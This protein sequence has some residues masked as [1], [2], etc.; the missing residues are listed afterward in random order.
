[1]PKQVTFESIGSR[2]EAVK[3]NSENGGNKAKVN[4][5]KLDKK[6]HFRPIGQVIEFYKFFV[7]LPGGKSR[8]FVVEEE[9]KQKAQDMIL[10]IT[11]EEVKPNLRFAINVIDR[12]DSQVKVLE[13]GLMIFS[14]F[15]EW[16][17]NNEIHPGSK[18]GH[19]WFITP[20]GSGK[21]RKYTVTPGKQTPITKEEAAKL[22][23]VNGTYSL[24]EVFKA[25]SLDKMSEILSGSSGGSNASS[26]PASAAEETD[27][28]VDAALNF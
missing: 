21:S 2:A 23:E 9:D 11:G 20:N 5:L 19:D 22:K 10:Q 15:S 1:M 6:V 17:Q 3:K 8:S 18:D 25:I 24:E 26:S 12:T 7:D 13:G 4:Y 14:V 27:I 28:D 16:K